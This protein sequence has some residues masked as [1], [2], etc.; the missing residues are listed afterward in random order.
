MICKSCEVSP[1]K[2]VMEMSHRQVKGEE[3]SV[4]RAVFPLSRPKLSCQLP[5]VINET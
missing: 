3:L 5:C 4:E 2:K 1:L